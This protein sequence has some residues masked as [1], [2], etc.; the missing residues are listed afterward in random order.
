M[1]IVLVEV[2]TLLRESM[3][4]IIQDWQAGSVIL[5]YDSPELLESN[6][7]EFEY[8]LIILKLDDPYEQNNRVSRIASMAPKS[9][10]VCLIDTADRKVVQ[11]LVHMGSNAIITSSTSSHEFLAILQLVMAGGIFIPSEVFRNLDHESHSNAYDK[12]HSQALTD[13]RLFSS[14]GL[15]DRQIEVLTLLCQGHSNKAISD[16]MCLS[17]NT[18]KAHLTSIFRLLSVRSRA[19]AMALFNQ[20]LNNNSNIHHL[21]NSHRR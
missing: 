1:N 6:A 18:I 10:L 7:P 17:I 19:E 14:Y 9:P 3:K 11:Q 21:P 2:N 16:E 12:K 4:K 8:D 20:N 5:E 13:Q 15:S